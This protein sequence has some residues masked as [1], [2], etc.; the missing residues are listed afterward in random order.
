MKG[1]IYPT[2]NENRGCV[3]ERVEAPGHVAAVA[4]ITFNRPTYLRKALD[5]LLAV[6]RK[7]PSF[8]CA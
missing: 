6:H 5:S 3:A 4:M 1:A 7:E 2:G 8:K